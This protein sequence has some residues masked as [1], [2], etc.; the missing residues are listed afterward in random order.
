[1]KDKIMMGELKVLIYKV[2]VMLQK[3]WSF[4]GLIYQIIYRNDL[5]EGVVVYV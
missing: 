5:K 1:M 2:R 3:G 4:D